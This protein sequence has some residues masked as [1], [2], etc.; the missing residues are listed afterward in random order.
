MTG[1]VLPAPQFH[2]QNGWAPPR[3][4]GMHHALVLASRILA[5]IIAGIAFYFAFFLYEDEE[6]V[7]QNRLE[8]LW[9]SVYDR[10]KV[11]NSTSIALFNRIA[12]T[13]QRAFSRIFGVRLLSFQSVFASI[14]LS[15]SSGC[16]G[17][18]I[19]FRVPAYP[20]GKI[21]YLPI[22]IVSC[23]SIF[24]LILALLPAIIRKLWVVILCAVP[25][26]VGLVGLGFDM[27]QLISSRNPG[28][29]IIHDAP[30]ATELLMLTIALSLLS[31]IIGVI[32]IRKIFAAISKLLSA[33]RILFAVVILIG[34]ALLVEGLPVILG[35]NF[36]HIH[37][38]LDAGLAAIIILNASTVVYCLI[39]V[40]VLLAVL[41][42]QL[43][44][45]LLSRLLYPL[46]SRKVITNRKVLIPLG[47]LALT[48]AFNL[49]HVGAK[50]LLKLLS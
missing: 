3:M 21:D 13:L 26:I 40:A 32:I 5:G 28:G 37:A 22:L 9:N 19:V 27:E 35:T 4:A 41:G 24:F 34:F 18:M 44:W 33:L 42:H 50:E 11:T 7:W 39:P 8:N 17:S 30:Q 49:E 10:A 25:A 12:E 29:R 2:C 15:F 31:D 16:F 20:Q 1:I 23:F 47:T 48:F 43:V 14:N 6:G 45:P 36:A 38:A 46:A